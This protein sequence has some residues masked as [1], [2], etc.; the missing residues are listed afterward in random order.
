MTEPAK[1]RDRSG[2]R[3]EDV[4]QVKSALLTVAVTLGSY[5]DDLTIVGGLVPALLIDLQGEAGDNT[6]PGTNDL[7]VALAVGLLDDEQYAEISKRL[8][9]EG[10]EPDT[11][12]NGN[13]APQRWRLGSLKVTIDFLIAPTDGGAQRIKKLEPDFGAV[14]TP[15][16]GLAFEDRVDVQLDG[17]TLGGELV[18]RRV[19]VCGAAAFTVLKAL[20]IEGRGEP[21]DAFDLVYVLRYV[22]GGSSAV[23]DRLRTLRDQASVG[24]AIEV[25]ARDFSEIGS[26]GP[27][28]AA[29]FVLSHT[30]P[31]DEVDDEA[32]DALGYVADLL[33]RWNEIC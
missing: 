8:R 30:A 22:A 29:K 10:F 21:K 17:A 6:H 16:L 23:A 24:A 2:Y 5:M 18:T 9:A 13:P 32:A 3:P 14:V 20:A 33:D 27:Q 4:E 26:L 25:L 11:N 31:R 15:G 28:R 1:P 19:W 7:D 12:S